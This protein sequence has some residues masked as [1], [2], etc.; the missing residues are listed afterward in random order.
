MSEF[1]KKI[2]IL[3]MKGS[4]QMKSVKGKVLTG[5]VAVGVL[6]GAGWGFANTDAGAA[7][8]NW[9]NGQ[10]N[11][12]VMNVVNDSAAHVGSKVNALSKEYNGLKTDATASINQT[13]NTEKDEAQAEIDEVTQSHIDAINAKEEAISTAISSQFDALYTQAQSIINTTGEQAEN[14]ANNDLAKHTGKKGEEA[15]SALTN[16]LTAA[17]T[18]A[19]TELNAE[20]DAAKTKLQNQLNAEENLSKQEIK[21]AIDSKIAELRVSITTKRDQL[22]KA[23]QD[24]IAARAQELE[25]DA[26]EQLNAAVAGINN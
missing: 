7:L 10:F 8:Q 1:F 20:I 18:S 26:K 12:S 5:V 6:T 24:L 22:V 4:N 19:V 14:Y 13:K 16:D 21:A 15:L 11:K 23:Q 17:T 2:N 25:D 9:Y 3:I